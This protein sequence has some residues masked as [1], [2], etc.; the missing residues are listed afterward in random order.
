MRMF[1]TYDNWSD[2]AAATNGSKKDESYTHQG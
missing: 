2:I 1:D